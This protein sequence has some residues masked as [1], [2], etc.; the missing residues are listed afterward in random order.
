MTN[1]IMTSI[2]IVTAAF[3]LVLLAS[4]YLKTKKEYISGGGY[5]IFVIASVAVWTIF[6][7][8][9][10]A[11]WG[12]DAKFLFM[13]LEYVGICLLPVAFVLLVESAF[14][15][16]KIFFLR[17]LLYSAVWIA[18]SM[19]IIWVN[20]SGVFYLSS[21][22]VY[23]GTEIENISVHYGWAS[24]LIQ[25]IV[26]GTIVICVIRIVLRLIDNKS[27][28]PQIFLIL[29]AIAFP[30]LTSLLY[31]FKVS[32]Y[33]YTAASFLFS[34]ILFYISFSRY[35]IIDSTNFVKR[36]IL[37][38]LKNAILIVTDDKIEYMNSSAEILFGKKLEYCSGRRLDEL[39]NGYPENAMSMNQHRSVVSLNN[40]EPIY[41][42]FRYSPIKP[43]GNEGKSWLV[44]IEN[45][46]EIMQ[47]ETQLDYLIEH[48]DASGLYNRTKLIQILNQYEEQERSGLAGTILFAASISNLDNLST[49][50]TND[51]R[52]QLDYTV[53]SYFLEK[54]GPR[55]TIARFSENVFVFF[56][57]HSKTKLNNFLSVLESNSTTDLEIGGQKF[58]V[59]FKLGV[60]L[61]EEGIETEDALS[62][63]MFALNNAIN[64]DNGPLRVYDKM[65]KLEHSLSKSLILNAYTPDY[66]Q[67]FF[68]EYQPVM[69]IESGVV[70]GAEAFTRWRHPTF[71]IISPAIFAPLFVKAG[72]M[73][74][75]GYVILTKVAR[76]L[77]ALQESFG[78]DFFVSVNIARQQIEDDNL[79]GKL[80]VIV[81]QAGIS[82]GSIVLEFKERD[83]S[84]NQSAIIA[85]SEK[86]RASGFRVAIDS[87]N[88]GNSSFSQVSNIECS[89]LKLKRGFHTEVESYD[90]K[91]IVKSVFFELCRQFDVTVVSCG[92]E[93]YTELEAAIRNGT[94]LMQ[95]YIFSRALPLEEFLEYCKTAAEKAIDAAKKAMPEFD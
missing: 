16:R 50:L 7:C 28:K 2:C 40:S 77:K 52:V 6:Y 55:Y 18:V 79:I 3:L 20:P 69:D 33:D 8:A 87:F 70:V 62:S 14:Y 39:I 22:L 59:Y 49:I 48:D 37:N 93:R 38:M 88:W 65:L 44:S 74:D 63:V 92:I 11:S 23:V 34:G 94:K 86:A 56:S 84:S 36:N 42:E 81:E 32:E 90:K 61:V 73:I 95:G 66:E 45:V 76:A 57:N 85:F 75:L 30:F 64:S 26:F 60:Y 13:R 21:E 83:V 41:L 91:H 9:K 78:E 71:G 89:I 1:Q 31:V 47:A 46:N 72:Y 24:Y 29:A 15:R 82:P 43:N 25:I 58:E 4:M 51:Q 67:D 80:S 35:G 53:A 10:C 54:A 68:I 27:P 17:T 12:E 19:L 5:Y